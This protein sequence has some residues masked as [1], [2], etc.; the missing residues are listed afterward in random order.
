M[1]G[2]DNTI[3]VAVGAQENGQIWREFEKLNLSRLTLRCQWE[4]LG[5]H[6]SSRELA[7]L[8]NSGYLLLLTNHHQTLW[9]NTT[10]NL[11]TIL[12]FGLGGEQLVYAQCGVSLIGVGE[13]THSRVW[14]IGAVSNWS[15]A[16]AICQR[17]PL[18]SIQPLWMDRLDFL[19]H[20]SVRVAGLLTT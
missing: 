6:I 16:R 8:Y 4:H 17:P 14:P 1:G 13:S 15:K 20:G 5:W 11:P 3:P 9:F 18:S 12:Q 10:T 19:Q 7:I 2:E